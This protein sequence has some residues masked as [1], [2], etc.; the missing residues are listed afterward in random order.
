MIRD[1]DA[2]EDIFALDSDFPEP[3]EEGGP[4]KDWERPSFYDRKAGEWYWQREPDPCPVT[5]LGFRGGEFIFVTA[6][7][8]IR[9]FRAG[10]LHGRGGIED[11]FA[12]AMWW[13]LKHFRKYD[14]IAKSPVGGLQS[15]RCLS[16]LMDQC[17]KVGLYDGSQP[18]RGVGTW[19]GPDGSPIVHA[20]DRVFA[21]GK[22]HDPGAVIDDA[23]YVIGSSRQAPSYVNEERNGYKWQPAGLDVCHLVQAHLEEWNWQDL[24]ARDLFL[25]GLWC[26]CLGDAPRWKPHKFVRAPAGSGKSTLLRYV[27]ALLGGAAHPVQ[28]T[29]SKAR[30]EE[31]FARTACALLLDEMESDTDVERVRRLQE[32][33]LLLSDDGA[34]GG[35]FH[36]EIDLHGVITMVA[37]IRDDWKA[38]IKSRVVV[39]ELRP[40]N[41]RK[42][43]PAPTETLNAM[44]EKAAEIS[45]ALRARAI[46]RWPLFQEN[47]KRVRAKILEL[48]GT[49]RDADQLGHLLAGWACM[50]SDEPIGEDEVGRLDRFAPYIVS[51]SDAADGSDDGGDLLNTLFGL[52]AQSWR[53]GDQLTIGQLVARA[54]EPDADDAR[55]T[56]LGYGLRFHRLPGEMASQAWL[57]IANKHPGLDKLLSEYPAFKGSRRGQILASLRR[58]LPSGDVLECKPSELPM[59]FAGVQSRAYLVPPGLLPNMAEERE[60]ISA[61]SS[62]SEDIPA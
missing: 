22:I 54:R 5:P 6:A 2:D 40:L 30:L 45:P 49:P 10:Q 31:H 9:Q 8:E 28:R 36:R 13:P 60:A 39:L 33:I 52:P 56:L 32:L 47:L 19:R 24:E 23:L 25:G 35:R 43:G 18:H 17:V 46:E 50:T 11:L 7:R 44:I 16:L 34:T 27:R 1:G 59:R 20:G 61:P 48:G 51:V 38:T 3:A 62:A 12:G 53:G 15:K 14:P 41:D 58:P 42:D 26:D 37:T 55:R 4:P 57:A 29:Y 21:E